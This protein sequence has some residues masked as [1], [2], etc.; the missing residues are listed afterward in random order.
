MR[1]NEIVEMDRK[2]Y[3]NTFNRAPVCF[4]RGEGMYLWDIDGK[5]YTDLLAE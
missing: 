5:R 1:L 2:Y 3:M 4:E